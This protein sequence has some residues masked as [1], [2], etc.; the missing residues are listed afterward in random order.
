MIATL[1]DQ[2]NNFPKTF[3]TSMCWS[4]MSILKSGTRAR[5]C[6][7]AKLVFLLRRVREISGTLTTL[8]IL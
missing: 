7:T 4:D 1:G 3:L 2:S 8:C 6:K 5:N